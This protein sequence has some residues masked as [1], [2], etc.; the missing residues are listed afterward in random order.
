MGS[1]SFGLTPVRS[2]V[3]CTASGEDG[4]GETISASTMLATGQLDF[5]G[6]MYRTSPRA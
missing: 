2:L 4:V 5:Q 6:A 3:E 1:Y